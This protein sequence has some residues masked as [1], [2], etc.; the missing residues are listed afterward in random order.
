MFFPW[1]QIHSYLSCGKKE[2]KTHH[3]RWLE[4]NNDEDKK[5]EL[6]LKCQSFTLFLCFSPNEL[7]WL[8]K[9]S[10]AVIFFHI[11]FSYTDHALNTFYHLSADDSHIFVAQERCP[12]LFCFVYTKKKCWVENFCKL[13]VSKPVL[14]QQI[15]TTLLMIHGVKI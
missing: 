6:W 5:G 12:V 9:F 4:H 2:S 8:I 7:L 1:I 14:M 15:Q 3:Q 13:C 11:C 10:K